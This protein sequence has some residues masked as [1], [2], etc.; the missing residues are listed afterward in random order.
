MTFFD[1]I[2]NFRN[3]NLSETRIGD[4]KLSVK[5]HAARCSFQVYTSRF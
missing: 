4:E 5:L 2:S 3:R 1:E